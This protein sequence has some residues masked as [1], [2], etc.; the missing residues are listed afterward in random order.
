MA[1]DLEAEF[2]ARERAE[3]G[4]IAAELGNGTGSGNYTFK[5]S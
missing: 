3:L 2:L 1:D 5:L 4:D